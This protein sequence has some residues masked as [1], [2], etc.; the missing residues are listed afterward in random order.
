MKSHYH[1]EGNNKDFGTLFIIATPIGNLKDI[2]IRALETLKSVDLILCEDTSC[3]HKLLKNYEITTKTTKYNDHSG[4][5]A[6]NKVLSMLLSGKN[7]ALISDAGT[8]L[9]SDPG[10]KLVDLCRQNNI[11]VT[12]IPGACSIIA[13]LSASG[14]PTDQFTF[15][16]FLPKQRSY[17]ENLLINWKD[18][19]GTIV[20]LE[21]PT[22]LYKTIESVMR[23][24]GDR[25]I[26]IC[27]EI[28]KK[29]EEFINITCQEFLN[30]YKDYDFLGEI[31]VII[32]KSTI[33]SQEMHDIDDLI[34]VMLKQNISTK[35]MVNLISSKT[36][37]SKRYI[38]S[39]ILSRCIIAK[40]L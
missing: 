22:R 11:T 7:I 21:N 18:F 38:Y 8:P 33:L 35:D 24:M 26:C 5:V 4:D 27:R 20:F 28:T 16:G 2:T 1:N 32:E 12:P 39:K 14:M 3:S 15:V 23:I 6:S 36:Q 37:I 19:D 40:S 34:D 10:F 9:I 31:V 25:R 13:S 29:F 17:I 30:L